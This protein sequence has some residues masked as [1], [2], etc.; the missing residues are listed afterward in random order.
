M[1]FYVNRMSSLVHLHRHGEFSLLDGVGTA[2][3]YA[4]RAA[5]LNQ[6]ALALT[7]HG[8]LAGVLYHANACEEYGIKS[9]VGIEA[10]FTSDALIHNKEHKRFHLVLLAK[11]PT[12]FTNLMRLSSLSWLPENFYYKPC[13]DWRL[14]RQYSEGLIASTSCM[15]GI[16]PSAI[17]A[18]DNEGALKYLNTMLDIFGDDLY[19]T[20]LILIHKRNAVSVSPH[21][22]FDRRGI[23]PVVFTLDG[24]HVHRVRDS[25]ID[26]SHQNLRLARRRHT[27]LRGDGAG[28]QTVL[29]GRRHFDGPAHLSNVDRPFQS[30]LA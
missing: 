20:L 6:S 30:V 9:I 11:N 21:Q 15:S 23:A 12:G 25:H 7:D 28:N 8:S 3:H 29:K 13:I 17:L 16:V 5:D 2:E 19:R 1:T 22:A 27:Q 24:D 18:G 26:E 14:L 4:K 10:Y